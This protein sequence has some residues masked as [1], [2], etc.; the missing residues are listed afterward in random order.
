MEIKPI[1]GIQPLAAAVPQ[2]QSSQPGPNSAPH[3]DPIPDSRFEAV[4]ENGNEIVYRA[5][6]PETG[7][8]LMEVPSE[9]VRRVSE[10]L[11]QLFQEGKLG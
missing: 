7:L 11:K 4:L 2:Q 10:R 5:T 6:D 8:V 9:E 3:L 1:T